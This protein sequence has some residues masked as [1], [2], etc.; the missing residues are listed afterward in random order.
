MP[1]TMV[2]TVV[3]RS[4]SVLPLVVHTFATKIASRVSS[5]RALQRTCL[6]IYFT[7]SEDGGFVIGHVG[8]QIEIAAVVPT[9]APT[10]E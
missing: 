6:R 4:E 7:S 9:P 10:A 5:H 2:A 3:E 1:A 8:R